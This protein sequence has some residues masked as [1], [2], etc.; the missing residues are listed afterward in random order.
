MRLNERS[1]PACTRLPFADSN[2]RIGRP[3]LY[4]RRFFEESGEQTADIAEVKFRG[5]RPEGALTM[6]LSGR[7]NRRPNRVF[8]HFLGVTLADSGENR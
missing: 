2:A 8:G 7:H 3:V 4:S 5:A 1:L 6:A